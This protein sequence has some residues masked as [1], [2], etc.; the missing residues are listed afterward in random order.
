MLTTLYL[1]NINLLNMKFFAIAALA[2]GLTLS[3][4]AQVQDPLKIVKWSNSVKATGAGEYD[5]VFTANIEKGWYT[6]SQTLEKGGPVPTSISLKKGQSAE[7]V[8]KAKEQSDHKK[9]GI[10]ENFGIKVTK[11][12]EKVTFT[13]HVKV[14][15]TKQP[16]RGSIEFMTCDNSKCLPPSEYEFSVIL[17]A[18]ANAAP[19][20]AT[21]TKPSTT[22]VDKKAGKKKK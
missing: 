7:L 15:D 2:L 4:Q 10:D 16:L 14:K 1:H 13:Q 18:T 11:F 22:A 3:A 9:E 20:K 5:I 12:A 17:P 8:G 6:Y 19:V 21:E